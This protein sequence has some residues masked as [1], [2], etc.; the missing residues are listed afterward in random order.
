[1]GQR[2]TRF[3]RSVQ[4]ELGAILARGGIKDPRVS[5][6]GLLTVTHV[7]VS[8]DLS[9]ARV[10][11]TLH[12]ADENQK[13]ALLKGLHSARGHLQRDLGRSLQSK[14]VPELRFELD[15]VDRS[16]DRVEELLREIAAEKKP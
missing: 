1:M 8:D 2:A 4:E 7:Q 3:A 15:E 12:G 11:V 16:A 6:A 9:V 14:K 13:K 5:E 10:L